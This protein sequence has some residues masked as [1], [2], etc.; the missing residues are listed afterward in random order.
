MPTSGGG[1]VLPIAQPSFYENPRLGGVIVGDGLLIDEETGI[2]ETDG[3]RIWSI[4]DGLSLESGV[5]SATGGSGVQAIVTL[6]INPDAEAPQTGEPY[7]IYGTE[8]NYY[9]SIGEYVGINVS[10]TIGKCIGTD[11]TTATFLID[12]SQ[13][14]ELPYSSAGTPVVG[15]KYNGH[16]VVTELVD[17]PGFKGV[18]YRQQAPVEKPILTIEKAADYTNP[19]FNDAVIIA[20]GVATKV[21]DNAEIPVNAVVGIVIGTYG[22]D[23]INVKIDADFIGSKEVGGQT[24]GTIVNGHELV[25]SAGDY[26]Y[27]Y[28]IVKTGAIPSHNPVSE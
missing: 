16:F 20:D 12:D 13:V 7:Y 25:I 14:Y 6:P 3:V 4:G 19:Q 27:S 22:D 5:L 26:S 23:T 28:T 18:I 21:A 10:D 15:Q 2:M 17:G 9:Q 8:G 1:Y 24:V 11:E